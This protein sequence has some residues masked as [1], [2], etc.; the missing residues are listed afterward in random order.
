[1]ERRAIR[2][3]AACA[4]VL[5]LGCAGLRS[6]GGE[7]I[8]AERP[9]EATPPGVVAPGVVQVEGGVVYERDTGAHE[10]D[11]RRVTAPDLEVR[12]GVVDPVELQLFVDG[13]THEQPDGGSDRGSFGDTAV[14]VKA[15]FTQSDGWRPSLAARALV[16]FPTGGDAE[17]SG[18]VDPSL[19]LLTQWDL[20]ERTQLVVDAG[21]G[22]PS[23]GVGTSGRLF[24]F[25]PQ[26]ALQRTIAARVAAYVEYAAVLRS[27]GEP[28]EHGVD[29]GFAWLPT[30]DLQLDVSAGLGLNAPAPDVFV[31]I[32][33]AWR[34]VLGR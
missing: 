25:A 10:P 4:A 18:G 9:G 7:P 22:T 24:E 11:T 13:W 31:A 5:L 26:I 23:R 28:D 29:G 12:I 8:E 34:F 33:G 19:A 3:V 6:P 20:S 1:M 32:G 16:S 27:A 14:G 17:T 30:D 21:L 2:A 15:C